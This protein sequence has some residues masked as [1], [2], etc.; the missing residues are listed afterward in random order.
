MNKITLTMPEI[1]ILRRCSL[2]IPK[3]GHEI[4]YDA[5]VE[6]IEKAKKSIK[7]LY[8]IKSGVTSTFASKVLTLNA[9]YN[10]EYKDKIVDQYINQKMSI[11]EIAEDSGLCKSLVKLWVRELNANKE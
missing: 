8:N 2:T 10:K 7:D 3:G 9:I 1:Q 4:V 6:E 11:R 5:T